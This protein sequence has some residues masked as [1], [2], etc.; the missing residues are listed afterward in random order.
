MQNA[1]LEVSVENLPELVAPDIVVPK[2]ITAVLCAC[3]EGARQCIRHAEEGGRRVPDDLSV[4]SVQ[5]G[6][7]VEGGVWLAGTVYQWDFIMTT[8]FD[9]LLGSGNYAG[10]TIARMTFD[11]EFIT[12]PSLA[13]PG[14]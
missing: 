5:R 2:G 1:G 13:P 6:Q 3:R 8:C 4:V 14:N 9:I 10:R 12:G 7:R 11:P